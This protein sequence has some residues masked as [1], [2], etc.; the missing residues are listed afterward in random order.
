MS[1]KKIIK[2]STAPEGFGKTADKLAP[3]MFVSKLPAQHSH[4]Y[5]EDEVLGL[6]VGVWDTTDMIETAGRYACDEFMWLLEGEATIKNN[7]TGEM[8]KAKAGE[9]FVIPRGYDCQWHQT[10]YL[11]KFYVISESP[12]EA[13]PQNPSFEGIIIPRADAPVEPLACAEPFLIRGTAPV[14]RQHICYRDNTGKF[15]SGTWESDPFE[16]EARP[17]PYNEFACVQ[18]GS[19]TLIDERGEEHSFKSG[20]ALFLPEGVVCSA[21]ATEKVRLFFAV[22]KSEQTS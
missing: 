18:T 19:L 22:L 9:P 2:L 5:Y 14:Q 12:N 20:D 1:A 6:Y 4:S 11:R 3:E 15:L 16:S 17:F 10:G 21:R 7:K 8:E 13:I